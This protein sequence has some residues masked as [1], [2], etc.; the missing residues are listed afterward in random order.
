MIFIRTFFHVIKIFLAG[1]IFLP[2][3]MMLAQANANEIGV[4]YLI[5]ADNK[6]GQGASATDT[7]LQGGIAQLNNDF[8]ALNMI[9]FYSTKSI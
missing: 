5:S 4:Y 1:V 9:F 3:A 8:S 2:S 6:N 7:Q